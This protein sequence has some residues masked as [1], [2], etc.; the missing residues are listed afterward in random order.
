[1]S[2]FGFLTCLGF[3]IKCLVVLLFSALSHVKTKIKCEDVRKHKDQS[4]YSHETRS[5]VNK[6]TGSETRIYINLSYHLSLIRTSLITSSSNTLNIFVYVKQ[7]LSKMKTFA[8]FT[9]TSIFFFSLLI[10][11]AL[12]QDIISTCSHWY[13]SGVSTFGYTCND[14]NGNHVTSQMDL[15][16]CVANID[17]YL[18]PAPKLVYLNTALNG[19]ITY[20]KVYPSIQWPI[21]DRMLPMPIRGSQHS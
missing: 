21:L 16:L 12:T 10:N 20:T 2:T 7:K 19:S 3:Q 4:T 5:T 6:Q 17:G 11:V 1:M 18:K 13:L 8:F 9:S 14:Q 15:N